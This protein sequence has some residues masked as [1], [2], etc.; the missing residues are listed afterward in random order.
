MKTLPFCLVALQLMSLQAGARVVV[1]P[2]P[3]DEP[4]STDYQ[5]SAGGQKVDVYTARVLDPP[6]A[7]T[8]YDYGGPYS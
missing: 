1:Y 6:F 5:V 3:T 7:G 4:L 8:E 2:A